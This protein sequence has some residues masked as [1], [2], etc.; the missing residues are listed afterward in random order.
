M[1]EA[2]T[3][4][5]GFAALER[6]TK[7]LQPPFA[8]VDLGALRHNAASMRRRAAGK[9]IRLASKSVRCRA[10]LRSVLELPGYQGILA[11]TLPEALWLADEFDEFDDVLIGYPTADTQALRRLAADER[12]ASR[13]TLMADCEEHLDLLATAAEAGAH[14][15]RVCLDLDASLR[16]FGGR[17]HFGTRRSPLHAPAQARALARAVQ[18]RTGLR[19]VGVMSYEAQIA[20]VG[21]NAPGPALQR[22]AI[23]SL[24][25]VSRDELARRRA[26]AIEA[27]RSVAPL[28][29][30][31]GGGTGSL[32]STSAEPAVTE[33]GAGSG[34]YGP[35][36]FDIYAGFRPRPA[37]FFVQPVVR[38]PTPG[39]ATLLGGG[40]VAS[41]AAG[42][43]RLPTPVWPT[44]LRLTRM[45]G[46]GEVQTPLTG[47]GAAR[48]GVGDRVWLRHTKAG[49]L[50]ER[51][52]LLHL[53]EDDRIVES[54]PTYRGEGQAFL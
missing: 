50:C 4:P 40:W 31:N 53:V 35:V 25:R 8:V 28:E 48:I 19:L 39:L 17:F 42:S 34:L 10:L 41:G 37:A 36:L 20:G 1:P 18:A 45:E 21:D 32:E 9:P 5:A 43:D 6:A 16:M 26:A 24:Q 33:L 12:L 44:G 54:V 22:A 7:D 3:T 2:H 38:R 11:F 51:V 15:L 47:P 29:F 27:V 23:R 49:E 13:I 52:N 14:P 46:A 30:V